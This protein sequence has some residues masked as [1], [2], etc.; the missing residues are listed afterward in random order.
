MSD[1][2]FVG[3]RASPE[4]VEALDL[5]ANE[6]RRSRS[7]EMRYRLEQ[8]FEPGE[9]VGVEVVG[10]RKDSSSETPAG[11]VVNPVS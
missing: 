8:S 4:L 9:L 1:G 11:V 5:S 3:F 7:Q 2:V 6:A 10:K